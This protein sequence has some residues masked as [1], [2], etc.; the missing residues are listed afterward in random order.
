M[1]KASVKG[2]FCVASSVVYVFDVVPKSHQSGSA[3]EGGVADNGMEEVGFSDRQKA[4]LLLT[5]SIV[6]DIIC[7]TAAK[8]SVFVVR[9][10]IELP[11]T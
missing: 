4:Q 8:N 5:N 9:I 10:V 2:F 7:N 1:Q 11:Q 6:I 3:L